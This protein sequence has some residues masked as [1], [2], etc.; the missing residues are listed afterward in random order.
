MNR[1]R[2]VVAGAVVAAIALLGGGFWYTR[3]SDEPQ[4]AAPA[5]HRAIGQDFAAA[6]DRAKARGAAIPPAPRSGAIPRDGL[7][8]IAGTVRDARTSGT[9]GNVEVVF[10]N[11]AGE[12]TTTAGPD[13]K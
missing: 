12:S 7:V 11:S 6:L 5:H 2:V 13:G 4:A 3:S 10:R 1:R 8:T 9:V